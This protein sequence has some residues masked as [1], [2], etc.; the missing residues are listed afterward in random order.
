MTSK[1][2]GSDSGSEALDTVQ[3][4]VAAAAST[5]IV[6]PD[7]ECCLHTLFRTLLENVE[8]EETAVNL[9]L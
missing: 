6:D 5:G 9:I 4:A 2:S 7:I 3:N 8:E 1:Q